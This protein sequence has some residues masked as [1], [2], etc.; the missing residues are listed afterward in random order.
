MQTNREINGATIVITGASSGFGRGAALKLAE[1][2][3]NVVL[4]ARRTEA[5]DALV[6]QINSQGGRAL[7]VTTDISDAAA[8]QRLAAAA[9]QEF[10]SFDVW[11]NNAGIGVLGLFWD[12]PLE[13]YDRLI[14]VNL[15]GL[16]YGAHVAINHFREQGRGTL[17]NVGSIDSE[18]PLAYQTVY[19]STKSAVLSI[20][21]SLNAELSLAGY[22]EI[23]VGTIMPWAVDTPWWTHAANYTGHAP[24]MAAMDD[25]QLVVDAIVDA[26]T[27]PK[28]EHPVGW[29]AHSSNV[30]HRVF[31][32]FSEFLTAKVA[33]H[34]VKKAMPMAPTTGAIYT[35]M[36]TTT[37]MDGGIRE[38]MQREDKS[39]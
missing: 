19:A 7:A 37:S 34:S 36:P 30:S 15:K 31:A 33:D 4:A 35:P 23:K 11:I 10:G 39:D 25:P 32:N 6:E 13:D 29:K 9:I 16:V 20:S 21:R 1:I 2:G 8:V 14:D 12:V 38:R 5:L 17:I 26:C 3:A 27:S 18:V 28:E 22:D 24:R